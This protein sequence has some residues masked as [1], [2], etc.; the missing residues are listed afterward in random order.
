M[1][2]EHICM[3]AA[4]LTADA[5]FFDR[6]GPGGVSIA[7]LECRRRRKRGIHYSSYCN[8]PTKIHSKWWSS[9]IWDFHPDHWLGFRQNS[10]VISNGSIWN[11]FF[12][13]SKCHW[14][15]IQNSSRIFG[16]ELQ[17]GDG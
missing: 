4:G 2:D 8:H 15:V 5:R 6:Q 14:S 13:E 12:L 11:L 3:A 7:S 16:T 10:K 17:G 9:A 1:L